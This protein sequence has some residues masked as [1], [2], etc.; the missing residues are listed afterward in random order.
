MG[1]PVAMTWVDASLAQC[2]DDFVLF[3]KTALLVL[4]KDHLAVGFYIEDT[5][6]S[7]D[8]LRL[9]AELLLELGCQTGSPGLVVSNRAIRDRDIHDV[10]QPRHPAVADQGLRFYLLL[11]S[12]VLK[13]RFCRR[14]LGPETPWSTGAYR[15]SR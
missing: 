13:A 1:T 8:Q 12:Q 7:R 10:M 6:T 3:G 4:R 9:Y 15:Q 11:P 2:R 5:T 14:G